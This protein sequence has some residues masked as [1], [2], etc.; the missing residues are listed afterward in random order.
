MN[1][2]ASR[3]R[4]FGRSASRWASSCCSSG[5]S[6]PGA[7]VGVGV[8]IA[9]VFGLLW[10]RDSRAAGP[11]PRAPSASPSRAT[12]AAAAP[13]K[14]AGARGDELHAREVPRG[15]DARPRRRDRRRSSRCR[16]SA[17]WCCRRS[18]TRGEAPRPRPARRTT[19]RASSSSR[20]SRPTRGGRRLA[21]HRLRPQ[22]RRRRRAS[23][24]A[25]RSSRTTARIS[26]ARCSRTATPPT[27]P[28]QYKD[29]T[30]IP[31][32]TPPSGFGCPCHG[33][34]YDTEGNRTAGPPVRALDRY[35][36]SIRN[37][38]S[39]SAPR[40][41]SPRSRARAARRAIH[42]WKLAFPG[43]HVD[44]PESWLYPIQPPH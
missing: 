44:G 26:A 30:L 43:E 14:R 29:V 17:S 40:S 31:L 41:R 32:P 1:I 12:A 38:A 33:G 2:R 19:P 24:R 11:R 34:Q 36:F 37:G 28:A 42:K 25:S 21:R 27:K 20:R 16:C 23:S 7:I 22:Q 9:F 5:S 10:V 6:W 35:P 8:V 13:A 15:H 3:G 39:S 4:A 18:S